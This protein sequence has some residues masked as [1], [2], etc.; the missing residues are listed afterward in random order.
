MTPRRSTTASWSERPSRPSAGNT[1]ERNLK[2]QSETSQCKKNSRT[3]TPPASSDA[4]LTLLSELQLTLS[5]EVLKFSEPQDSAMPT[6][7]WRLV[8]FLKEK[9]LSKDNLMVEHLHIHRSSSF[10]IGRQGGNIADI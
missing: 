3:G 7:Y 4:R 9:E 5:N 10:L 8:P 1:K 6:Y 2:N